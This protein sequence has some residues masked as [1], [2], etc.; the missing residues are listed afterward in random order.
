MSALSISQGEQEIVILFDL[1]G[2]IGMQI[3]FK[4]YTKRPIGIAN[5]CASS[6][7]RH[8]VIIINCEIV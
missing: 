5:D 6:A 1:S 7:G 4:F 2:V 8:G 3:C